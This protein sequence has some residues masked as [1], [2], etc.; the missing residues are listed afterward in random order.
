M[1]QNKIQVL[2]RPP[3]KLAGETSLANLRP[4]DCHIRNERIL[5]SF[6]IS[7]LRMH[8]SNKIEYRSYLWSPSKVI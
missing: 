2:G 3:A 8:F 7:G 1:K 4:L 5:A 6:C